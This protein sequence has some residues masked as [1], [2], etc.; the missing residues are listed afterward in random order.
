MSTEEIVDELVQRFHGMNRDGPHGVLKYVNTANATLMAVESEKT[1]IVDTTTGLLP[2]LSTTAGVYAYNMP[3][4]V[5]RVSGILILIDDNNLSMVADYGMTMPRMLR[6]TEKNAVSI[7]GRYYA[8]YPYVKQP[9]DYMSAT[10][11]AQ[12]VFSKDPE[13]KTN[14]YRRR[15]Y[16][17]PTD[18]LSEGIQS[19]F[20][21]PSDM[22]ILLPAAAKLIEGVQSF[23][24]TEAYQY[25]S[26]EFK[27][28][29][30][31]QQN[32]GVHGD[33]D[34]EPVDRGF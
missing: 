32:A 25:V 33:Y 9:R 34:F 21:P 17:R 24:Y 6:T 1:L 5:W 13:T 20:P 15:S 8:K 26:G 4:N 29:Y 14:Y 7:A 30:W 31:K 12:I 3:T 18:I 28:A 16:K 2:I 22:E 10:V 27:R 23:N 11:P 19:D